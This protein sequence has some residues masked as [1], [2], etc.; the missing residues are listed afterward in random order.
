MTI[1]AVI[2]DL[3]GTLL[4]TLA[5]IGE[6]MNEVLAGHGL[7]VHDI[8]EYRGFIGDGIERLVGRSLAAGGRPENDAA[9][10]RDEFRTV[11]AT[12]ST[13]RT[14][15]YP[16]I[17]EL[18]D[19]LGDRDLPLSVLSN[20][21]HELTC[22]VIDGC[23]G[24]VA[25]R[26][27]RGSGPSTLRKPDPTAGLEQAGL[28]GAAPAETLVVGDSGND[29]RMARKAGMFGV[30]ALWGFREARELSEGGADRLIARP[31]E[32]L[33]IIDGL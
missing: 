20:K 27:V 14:V 19:E 31:S 18:L 21:P 7:P 10:L 30:G 32:L 6:S 33:E 23:L 25:F 8:N 13:R 17:P 11:Y 4:D 15:P 16:G 26:N 12:R 3:D 24:G 29:M 22:Q 5:D 28:M 1:A 9:A 2:F